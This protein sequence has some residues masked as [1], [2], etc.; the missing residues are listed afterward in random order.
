MTLTHWPLA[1]LRLR[2]PR[3]E[4][5]WP[6]LTDLDELAGLAAE[7]VHDPGVQPFGVPWTS[8]AFRDNAASLAVSGKLG[9]AP[10][11][12]ERQVSRG[13]PVV[14]QRLRLDRDSWQARPRIP[15]QIFGLD[16]C[17]PYFGLPG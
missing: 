8:G 9:Y 13:N 14:M 3:L 7:G 6:T 16:P 10:D 1:A 17:L 11:G 15:V 2:A 12:I 5:R 4:L